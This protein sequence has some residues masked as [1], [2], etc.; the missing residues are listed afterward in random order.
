MADKNSYP[1]LESCDPKQCIARKILK[2]SRM[3]TGIFRKYLLPF[4]ITYSQL[5]I[6]FIVAKKGVVQQAFLAEVLYLEKSTVSRNMKR[7]FEQ[8]YL[9]KENNKDIII[10]EKGKM[11]L[12]NIVPEW[13]KAMEE[14]R[15]ILQPKGEDALDAILHQ[16]VQ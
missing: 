3:I 7:L 2:S 12:E 13:E 10:T 11:L 14:A 8:E 4:N 15:N 5:S 6:L 1:N 9:T 16:L